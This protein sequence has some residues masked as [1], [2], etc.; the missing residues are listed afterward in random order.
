MLQNLRL[1]MR[2]QIRRHSTRRGNP[3]SSHRRLGHLWTRVFHGGR[4]ARGQ[5]L[6]LDPPGAAQVTLGLQSYQ[7]VG[8][9]GRQP[10]PCSG[11]DAGRESDAG[12]LP[13]CLAT[14]DPQPRSP[15]S[16]PSPQSSQSEAELSPVSR[17]SSPSEPP[18]PLQS[19]PSAPNGPPP[20]PQEAHPPTCR[21]RT[22]RKLVLE[23]AVN[24]KGVS[25]KRYSSLGPL[26]PLPP[27]PQ[28]PT[29][30]C[31]SQGQEVA[32]SPEP[33]SPV[34]EEDNN[35]HV[36]VDVPS[37]E[38]RGGGEKRRKRRSKSRLCSFNRTFNDEGGDSGRE[39]TP[40]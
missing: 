25:L 16:S 29:S 30:S 8:T 21:T 10:S 17:G 26:S 2:R 23:L 15:E 13:G 20:A 6:L 5:D 9:R 37:R 3:L 35:H 34:K 27:Q 31:H 12:A 14:M 33:S 19:G 40:C 39:M 4:R 36:T 24:L 38:I 7:T 28:T 32:S 22:S 18:T 11:G 1:A